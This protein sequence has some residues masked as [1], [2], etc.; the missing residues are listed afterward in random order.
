[1]TFL[2][3]FVH[4]LSNTSSP[5]HN[6]RSSSVKVA[7]GVRKSCD[8]SI[9]TSMRNINISGSQN[10]RETLATMNEGGTD[11]PAGSQNSDEVF[12]KDALQ[13][14]S[15]LAIDH[16]A[17]PRSRSLIWRPHRKS[18]RTSSETSDCRVS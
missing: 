1:M 14:S 18:S 8:A 7:L 2:H 6:K 16:G 12:I 13:Q 11:S 17:K 3:N 4:C 9:V 15:K 5:N 10:S